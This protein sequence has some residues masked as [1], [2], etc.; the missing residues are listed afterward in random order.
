MNIAD[1]STAFPLIRHRP[2]ASRNSAR[3]RMRAQPHWQWF[4]QFKRL[5]ELVSG[6]TLMSTGSFSKR[7]TAAPTRVPFSASLDVAP[8]IAS[9]NTPRL[10]TITA[11]FPLGCGPT[12]AAVSTVTIDGVRTLEIRFDKPSPDFAFSDLVL[13]PYTVALTYAPTEA[14]DLPVRM[15]TSDDVPVGESVVVTR[16]AKGNDAQFDVTGRWID[17]ATEETGLAFV[18]DFP[19][20]NCVVGTWNFH[21]HQG[22]CH[23]Y[24]IQSVHWREQYVEAEGAIFETTPCG[25]TATSPDLAMPPPLAINQ[26]GLARITFYGLNSA[27]IFALGFGGNVLFTSNLVRTTL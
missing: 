2:A 13:V 12:D 4:E 14:G 8:T 15:M 24:S 18:P 19:R 26:L 10:L 25:A 27:R 9:I 6:M 23:H 21:D 20:N 11:F 7:A 5:K 22:I 17:P 3:V 16:C 1:R